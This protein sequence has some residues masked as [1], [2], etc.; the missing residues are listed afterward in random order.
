VEQQAIVYTDYV[1]KA[2]MSQESASEY[3]D[4]LRYYDERKG[5][6]VIG[7]KSAEYTCDIA[8]RQPMI[9]PN[10][11]L[12]VWC[13]V[14]SLVPREWHRIIGGFDEKMSSWEDW[15]YWIR[16]ARAG[17]C[18]YHL[19]EEL[20]VYRFNTGKRREDGLQDHQ[21]LL[22]YLQ[23]K[24]KDGAIMPCG[25][26]KDAVHPELPKGSLESMNRSVATMQEDNNFKMVQYDHPNRGGHRVV[27]PQTGINYGY[28]SGGER[29]LVDIRDIQSMPHIF[30]VIQPVVAPE[31]APP[32]K[33]PEPIA[34]VP[35]P[36]VQKTTADVVVAP[37]AEVEEVKAE[38]V[39]DLQSIPGI[40]P[41]AAQQ[42]NAAGV[43]TYDDIV[44]LG[45]EG[46][47][48]IKGIGWSRARA[49]LAFIKEKVSQE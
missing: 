21:S 44:A 46:L 1:G 17:K 3:R 11:Y 29:F 49:I 26:R 45:E 14:T 32:V 36:K 12:Y 30:R 43:H 8:V 13:L 22:Q 18:F 2:Q 37:E 40:T 9:G 4:K 35:P 10:G 20:V 6:A 25:C 34:P 24:Y 16:M 42:L 47:M 48:G 39:L 5:V 31:P 38:I 27:G 19:P 28:R 7:Y 23:D 15:D 41:I 33:P